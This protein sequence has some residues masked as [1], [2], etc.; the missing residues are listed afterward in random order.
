MRVERSLRIGRMLNGRSVAVLALAGASVL[1]SSGASSASNSFPAP[2]TA[3][4]IASLVAK[5]HL[6]RT[7]PANLDPSL[8]SLGQEAS[9]T[10]TPRPDPTAA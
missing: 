3:H 8:G 1:G 7:L 10:T 5:S 6:I 4:E 9:A 2:G